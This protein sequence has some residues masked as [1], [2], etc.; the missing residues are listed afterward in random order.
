MVHIKKGKLKVALE[1]RVEYTSVTRCGYGGV[2]YSL[3]REESPCSTVGK[4]NSGKYLTSIVNSSKRMYKKKVSVS[5]PLV[6]LK[7]SK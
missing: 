2:C 7:G 6:L 1:R 5:I 4:M 3:L